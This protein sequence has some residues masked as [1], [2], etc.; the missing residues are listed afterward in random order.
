M[1]W[2]AGRAP[3]SHLNNKTKKNYLHKLFLSVGLCIHFPLFVDCWMRF[4]S[5]YSC[6]SILGSKRKKNEISRI[7]ICGKSKQTTDQPSKRTNKA[8][9][10]CGRLILNVQ[11]SLQCNA[12]SVAW[13]RVVEVVRL[14]A[15]LFVF[16]FDA[17]FSRFMALLFSFSRFRIYHI[18]LNENPKRCI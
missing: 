13:H 8:E 5:H 11:C 12:Q 10:K 4:F 1:K 2:A 17:F 18:S 14:S 16:I 9:L 6:L 7:V 3:L 15:T